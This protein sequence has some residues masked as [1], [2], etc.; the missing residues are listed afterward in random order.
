MHSVFAVRERAHWRRPGRSTVKSDRQRSAGGPLHVLLVEDN[1][2]DADLCREFLE[3][4]FT[5]VDVEHVTRLSQALDKLHAAERDLIDVVLLDLNLPDALGLAAVVDIRETAPELP[6]VVLTGKDD[7]NLGRA[8]I[9]EH[10]EDCC[11]KQDVT[12]EMLG[13]VV[14]HAVERHRW[15]NRYRQ[16]LEINPDGMVVLD[17]EN[18]VLYANPAA[19]R[20]LGEANALQPGASFPLPAGSALEARAA[21][22][23]HATPAPAV[24]APPAELLL[25]NDHVVA[26]SRV[27][28]DWEGAPAQLVT[29]RDVTPSKRA[30]Q[31]L[32]DLVQQDQLTGLASRAHFLDFLGHEVRQS[33]R[34]ESALALMFIDLDRFKS[35][36][37]CLGHGVG[38]ILLQHVARRL[39]GSVRS[40]DFLGRLGG[41]EFGLI[42]PAIKGPQEAAAVAEKL[43][44]SLA[45][46]ITVDGRELTVGASIG[47]AVFP[48]AGL[49]ADEL[50][51]AADTAMY[52][53][54]ESGRNAYHFYSEDMQ[55]Q[56]MQRMRLE[57]ALRRSWDARDFVLH[58]QPLWTVGGD[59]L[60]ALEA[61]LRWPAAEFAH[62]GPA[63]FVPVAEEIGLI[64]EL[65]AWVLR[66]AVA[67]A[68]VWR[69]A[70]QRP[71]RVAVNVSG[72]QL[73]HPGFA[74]MVVEAL[75]AF[76]VA[77]DCLELEVTE[78]VF[79]EDSEHAAQMLGALRKI[80]VRTVIDDF[81]TGYSSLSYLLKL[82]ITGFKLDKRFMDGLG[83]GAQSEA[84]IEN[85]IRMAHAIGLQVTAEGVETATQRSFL[86]ICGCDYVQGYLFSAPLAAR[87]VTAALKAP[88]R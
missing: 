56:A 48:G 34:R 39:A 68:A 3:R 29:M 30:E 19:R 21:T 32:L 33:R 75:T 64:G 53:A 17:A 67:Q 47:I 25:P 16:L 9:R 13:R 18:L 28:V 69:Q 78:S 81:G 84:I 8:A 62:L 87:E 2:A 82:P 15:R 41:D 26:V 86:Q 14:V 42:L 70:L 37:D 1:L 73:R 46:P 83:H 52:R 88:P 10:A 49:G 36:N 54:K 63:Q 55:A 76:G 22:P 38:D 80:G 58:F 74:E 77:P 11:P 71:I 24:A 66:E 20:L 85:L 35:I 60:V 45:A 51:R 44:A 72:Q 59:R 65:G 61:L 43:L 27:P 79:I 57:A 4:V 23:P 50:L 12:P 5:D 40:S 31:R 6:V 7:A